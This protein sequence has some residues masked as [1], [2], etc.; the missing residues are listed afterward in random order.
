ML[1]DRKTTDIDVYI[2]KTLKKKREIGVSSTQPV[3]RGFSLVLLLSR[4]RTR[5]KNSLMMSCLSYRSERCV[6]G[7]RVFFVFHADGCRWRGFLQVSLAPKTKLRGRGRSARG[8]EED[9]SGS[10]HLQTNMKSSARTFDS[11]ASFYLRLRVEQRRGRGGRPA[12]L[13]L[14]LRLFL[15]YLLYGGRDVGGRQRGLFFPPFLFAPALRAVHSLAQALGDG[16]VGGQGVMRV[17]ERM[18][19]ICANKQNHKC[20]VGFFFFFLT[21]SPKEKTFSLTS[22]VKNSHFRGSAT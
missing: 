14:R 9:G 18:S 1:T 12:S 4:N 13:R 20:L 6:Q 7:Q 2:L 8:E 17:V 15:V 11:S 19:V 3:D 16:Q 22:S 21:V 5:T 10:S